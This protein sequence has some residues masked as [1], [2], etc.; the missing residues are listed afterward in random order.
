MLALASEF[1]KIMLG[2]VQNVAYTVYAAIATG[3]VTG[4][5]GFVSHHWVTLLIV[6]SVLGVVIDFLVYLF[7]WRPY[8]VWK[9]FY[10]RL[11]YGKTRPVSFPQPMPES[12]QEYLVHYVHPE[13]DVYEVPAGALARDPET[14]IYEQPT[15]D[16]VYE[17]ELEADD[18]SDQG[19]DL[20]RT[21]QPVSVRARRANR[22]YSHIRLPLLLQN[23]DEDEPRIRYR[24]PKVNQQQKESFGEPYIPPQWKQPE[25]SAQRSRPRR[26]RGGQ[27]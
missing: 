16:I 9:S 8:L 4:V 22:K 6:F 18:T 10:R 13:D 21:A 1:L 5:L 19:Q 23:E 7:R 26:R 24:A 17:Y 15:T 11:R 3:R 20:D 14:L 25:I 12:Q 27:S 2:W